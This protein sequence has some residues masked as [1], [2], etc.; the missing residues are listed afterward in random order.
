L[1]DSVVSVPDNNWLSFSI[2]SSS[3][4]KYLLVLD[5]DEVRSSVLE[6]LEPL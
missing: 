6:D 1:V 3:N 5:V 4:I 2:L